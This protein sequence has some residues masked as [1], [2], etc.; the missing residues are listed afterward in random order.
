MHLR[1]LLL[2]AFFNYLA[3]TLASHHLLSVASS[4]STRMAGP[5]IP[6]PDD[7]PLPSHF[8]LP[9]APAGPAGSS[10]PTEPL[11]GDPGH[12]AR[13]WQSGRLT[14]TNSPAS[15]ASCARFEAAFQAAAAAGAGPFVSGSQGG[16]VA[17]FGARACSSGSQEVPRSFAEAS[18][19]RALAAES[20]A[21]S[22]ILLRAPLCKFEP[23]PH[24]TL[25]SWS[26]KKLAQEA[27]A[28]GHGTEDY[29]IVTY[30]STHTTSPTSPSF[31]SFAQLSQNS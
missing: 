9:S 20:E 28:A 19:Q 15:N 14:F 23:K 26:R 1:P 30:T 10:A 4:Q 12:T 5:S 18:K 16:E 27:D 3:L 8:S 21:A 2:L 13:T 22:G 24:G 7:G 25:D 29:N 11:P 17:M 6:A 31:P